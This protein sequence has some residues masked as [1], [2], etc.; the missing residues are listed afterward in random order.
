VRAFPAF[1][2]DDKQ[3]GG[4]RLERIGAVRLQEEEQGGV[5]D[6][7]EA[8]ADIND[9]TSVPDTGSAPSAH[10]SKP[11][12]TKSFL[13]QHKG[14]IAAVFLSILTALLFLLRS[15]PLASTTC[16]TLIMLEAEC[17]KVTVALAAVFRKKQQKR[18][19]ESLPIAFLP[20]T[21]YVCINLLSFWALRYVPASS[22]AL[23][24]QIKLP[25]TAIISRLALKRKMSQPRAL[26][27]A[28]IC[29]GSLGTAAYGLLMKKTEAQLRASEQSSGETS[30]S[31]SSNFADVP[32]FIT[33][34]AT[35][36]LLF[37]SCLSAGTGV[38]LQW[39][40]KDLD[41]LWVRNAQFGSLSV[42]WYLVLH[43]LIDDGSTCSY[44]MDARGA[45]V[46]LLYATMG[47]VVAL[48]T[49]WLGATEK[50][51]AA[52]SAIVLTMFFDHLL[53]L[54]TLPTA[55]ELVLACVIV[56]G[57]VQFS[58]N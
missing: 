30:S 5:V 49:L 42:I 31:N 57:V 44:A 15:G 28:I 21:A 24:S 18:L 1:A 12:A 19:C 23:M 14:I 38:F 22:G 32:L 58:L 53:V 6:V 26:A 33:L 4:F 8:P 9:T 46:G 51:I 56:I 40:F 17:I 41:A 13:D 27:V 48:V 36:A 35:A 3:V 55:L 52:T 37:E 39:V 7:E 16:S 47:L 50:A 34:L 45:L 25:A 43:Q 10:A 11:L 2:V 54:Y 29:L 20:V